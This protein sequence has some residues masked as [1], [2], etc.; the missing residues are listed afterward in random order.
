MKPFLANCLS[1]LT[2]L[3]SL[4]TTVAAEELSPPFP[5]VTQS[6][7]ANIARDQRLY[8]TLPTGL[9]AQFQ[10]NQTHTLLMTMERPLV[11]HAG[12]TL[13]PAGADIEATLTLTGDGA[14]IIANYI[15]IEGLEIPI[16]AHSHPIPIQER[17]TRSTQEKVSEM[18]FY[19][20]PLGHGIGGLAFD[21]PN[22][23][24]V[25]GTLLPLLIGSLF[26]EPD[27]QRGAYIP[28]QSYPLMIQT[29]IEVPAYILQ[30]L[31]TS[32]PP[33]TAP[34]TISLSAND[35]IMN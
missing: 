9:T 15:L 21:E 6:T 1:T 16:Q 2:L 33:Q 19:T 11:N 24:E 13:I 17:V 18:L 32:N 34:S 22:A 35:L 31:Q 29:P 27:V 26:I 5:I 3:L 30:A 4:T 10:N 28:E 25:V 23:G 12:Q 14:Q 20:R 7:E 8:V